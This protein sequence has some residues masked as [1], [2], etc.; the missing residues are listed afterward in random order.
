VKI[1]YKAKNQNAFT[2]RDGYTDFRG[3]YR[4]LNKQES[5]ESYGNMKIFAYHEEYGIKVLDI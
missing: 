4:Y 1:F 5:A 3:M 2:F